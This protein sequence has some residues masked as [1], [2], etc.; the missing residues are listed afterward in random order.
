MMMNLAARLICFAA[1][2]NFH[3]MLK[4]RAAEIEREISE[5]NYT[6]MSFPSALFSICCVQVNL[7]KTAPL[8]PSS[9]ASAPTDCI[10]T[11]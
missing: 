7:I 5:R 3:C 6:M 4:T 8:S 9:F 11:T 10:K 2:N 1:S